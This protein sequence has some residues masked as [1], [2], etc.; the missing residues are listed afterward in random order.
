ME[1]TSPELIHEVLESIV[2]LTEQRDQRS[3]ENSLFHALEE[4]LEDVACQVL[5]FTTDGAYRII[6]ANHPEREL[7]SQLLQ[8][9]REM[10]EDEESCAL[11]Q[12]GVHY[13]LFNLTA[14][15]PYPRRVLLLW[16]GEWDE[17]DTRLAQ[18]MAQVYMNFTRL[19]FD[20]EKD[21]LTGLY[22]RKR[23]EA[24]LEEI[25]Q[26]QLNSRREEDRT[27][28]GEYLALLDL[29]HFK[30]IND[31]HGHL[32][33]DEVLLI[34]ANILRESLRDTDMSFRY[35][36][37]EFLVLL[38][39]TS[40]ENARAVLERIRRNVETHAFPQ[41]GRVTVSIGYSH[42]DCTLRPASLALREADQALYYAKEQGRNQVR[43][44]QSLLSDGLLPPPRQDGGMEMF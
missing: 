42:I 18:G 1:H 43:D 14:G 7:P 30:R 44:Y 3:L 5:E 25:T 34:F 24:R 8:L 22:N 20:S 4:M 27:G 41:V 10:P 13:Q 17:I 2:V 15:E 26:A 12:A 6:H 9:A 11:V 33:G 39:D 32:I 35:G 38:N 36:G 37:E 23:L 29:D 28:R 40:R 31:E 16:R 19:L 21:T